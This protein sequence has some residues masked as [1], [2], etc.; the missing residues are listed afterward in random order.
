MPTKMN[1]EL[2]KQFKSLGI[3]AEQTGRGVQSEVREG[4]DSISKDL[5]R[6]EKNMRDA[7]RSNML[8]V[9]LRTFGK[10]NL[11]SIE[12]V[13]AREGIASMQDYAKNEGGRTQD[14]FRDGLAEKVTTAKIE[15]DNASLI[16]Y[17]TIVKT[18]KEL[19][20]SLEDAVKNKEKGEKKLDKKFAHSAASGKFR[21]TQYKLGQILG[22][23]NI[24]EQSD[25]LA[26]ADKEVDDAIDK[27]ARYMPH[28]IEYIKDASTVYATAKLAGDM[29]TVFGRGREEGGKENAIKLALNAKPSDYEPHFGYY[30]LDSKLGR[31]GNKQKKDNISVAASTEWMN[32]I[33]EYYSEFKDWAKLSDD[34]RKRFDALLSSGGMSIGQAEIF[35]KEL[36]SIWITKT[37]LFSN[38]EKKQYGLKLDSL[39]AEY[40]GRMLSAVYVDRHANEIKTFL[41]GKDAE[42]FNADINAVRVYL[43]TN[44]L[45]NE[46]ELWYRIYEY[47]R[48]HHDLQKDANRSKQTDSSNTSSDNAEIAPAR[49]PY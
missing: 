27:L 40:G 3:A 28:I 10:K 16:R 49:G 18:V 26:D 32:Y 6:I 8:P 29:R 4:F 12:Y 13:R 44:I 1:D 48:L 23:R 17:D 34:Q 45:W 33:Q 25:A 7:G 31:S 11:K 43:K 21:M 9:V 42:R 19:A 30:L 38:D 47:T 20:D 14:H 41:A 37:P 22:A 5:Y 46:E 2:H 24:E 36:N 15:W 35:V 39:S